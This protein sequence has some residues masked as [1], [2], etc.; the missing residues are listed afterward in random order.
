MK[1][2]TNTGV[3]M[4]TGLL[5]NYFKTLVNRFFKILPMRESEEPSLPVY[6]QSLQA[7]LLG[8]KEL[9]D[10]FGDDA[11]YLSLLSVLQFLLDH[12]DCPVRVVKREVFK[13]INICNKLKARF[14]EEVLRQ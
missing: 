14:P 9:I 3:P 5:P 1:T 8:C 12:P 6:I 2:D 7:E 4:Q 13:C 10:L 11:F